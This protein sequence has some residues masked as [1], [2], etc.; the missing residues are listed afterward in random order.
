MRTNLNRI[1]RRLLA[2]GSALF[3]AS[4]CGGKPSPKPAEPAASGTPAAEE[5]VLNLYTHRHY[6][7]DDQ[8]FEAFT[9][10]TGIAIQVTSAGADQ[11]ISRI[12]G[13]GPDCPADLLVTVDAGRLCRARDLGLLQPVESPALDAAIPA[14]LRDPGH[15]WFGFTVRA[16]VIA[17]AKARVQPGQ[18]TSY[19]DLADPKWKGRVLVRSGDSLYNQS[20]VAAMVAN[21]GPEKT[22][23]WV[24]GLTQNL[25]RKPLGGDRDQVMALAQNLGDVALVNSYYL[26]QMAQSKDPAERAAFAQ[27][28]LVFPDQNGR[29]THINISGA[30]VAKYAKHPDNARRVLEFLARPAAQPVF[31][32]PS[33]E[34]PIDPQ[35]DTSPLHREWGPYRADTLNLSKLGEHYPAA[36]AIIEASGW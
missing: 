8:L 19:A 21:E 15:F 22:A 9:K 34:Y 2:V 29:G 31:P 27:V 14:A 23:A 7:S 32:A 6:E 25:A 12:K 10:L 1:A 5:P 35:F 20:L 28:A 36:M 11:L 16:R 17:Y 33:F 3:L 26:G 18:I 13:E 24:Q 30:G 4:S